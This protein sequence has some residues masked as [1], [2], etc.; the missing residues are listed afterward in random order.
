MTILFIASSLYMIKVSMCCSKFLI[1]SDVWLHRSILFFYTISWCYQLEIMIYNILMVVPRFSWCTILDSLTFCTVHLYCTTRA[2]FEPQLFF[3]FLGVY[4]NFLPQLWLIYVTL[5]NLPIT[6]HLHTLQKKDHFKS[7]ILNIC[8]TYNWC[9]EI[10][11][12]LNKR[13][14]SC[15]WK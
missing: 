14:V 8:I 2:L 7:L 12:Q 3:S 9:K 11:H 13:F 10:L 6:T 1:N 5:K 15:W 4:C